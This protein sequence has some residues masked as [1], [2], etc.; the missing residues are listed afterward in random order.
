M[1]TGKISPQRRRDAEK[2]SG[3]R[4]LVDE[5]SDAFA[6]KGDVEID[7][8]AELPICKTQVGEQ[9]CAV[10][11]KDGADGFQFHDDCIFDDKID[12]IAAVDL[13]PLVAQR[14][15]QLSLNVKTFALQLVH[16]TSLVRRFE[17]S[18]T[19]LGVHAHGA[20]DDAMGKGV[21]FVGGHGTYG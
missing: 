21:Q 12:A 4:E 14:E 10:Y 15:I 2:K 20:S 6:Q 5:A 17:Q 13:N 1:K 16:E 7:Q 11:R 9:L 3:V 18:G 8:E 19:K